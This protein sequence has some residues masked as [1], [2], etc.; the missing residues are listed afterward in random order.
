MN[1]NNAYH[2]ENVIN[3]NNYNIIYNNIY[4][5]IENENLPIQIYV[6]FA[7]Q[8]INATYEL[9]RN[10]S[11]SGMIQQLQENILRDFGTNALQ[12]ELVEAGQDMPQGIPAEEA[13]AFVVSSATIQQRFNNNDFVAFYIRRYPPTA[14]SSLSTASSIISLDDDLEPCCMVCQETQTTL[15]TYFGCSHH[16]CDACCSGCIQAG[17]ERCAICRHH[18]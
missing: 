15:T 1:Q 11:T 8:T 6:K 4:S 14:S 17:I 7:Y 10:L 16:I 18:R 12:Y 5:N 2:N 3:Y 9:S 13:P